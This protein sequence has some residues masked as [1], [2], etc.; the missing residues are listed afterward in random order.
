MRYWLSLL[1]NLLQK[2]VEPFSRMN[3]P[4]FRAIRQGNC[5]KTEKKLTKQNCSRLDAKI[6][7]KTS[8]YAA[9][10]STH[11]HACQSSCKRNANRI[12]CEGKKENCQTVR[13]NTFNVAFF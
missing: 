12:Y 9:S 1:G 13:S 7:F 3:L 6:P 5:D 2:L 8:S 11:S 10:P 4:V